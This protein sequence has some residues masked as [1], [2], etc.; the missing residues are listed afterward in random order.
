[1]EVFSANEKRRSEMR[2]WKEYSIILAILLIVFVIDYS[3]DKN[4]G[5]S[6]NWMREGIVSIENKCKEN[7]EEEAQNEF[8]ELEQRWKE[9]QEMLALFVEHNELE[10][11]SGDIVLIQSNFDTNDTDELFQNIADLKFMLEHIE[12]KNKL[13]LKNIF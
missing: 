13:K 10:K 1:M 12:E 6:V 2:F 4:L 8:Y 11:I 7:E 3:T 9:E 5:D